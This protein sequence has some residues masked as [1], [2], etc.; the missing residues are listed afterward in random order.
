MIQQF[1]LA[2]MFSGIVAGF[3]AALGLLSGIPRQ[4]QTG[5]IPP[6]LRA[7]LP[8]AAALPFVVGTAVP[9]ALRQVLIWGGWSSITVNALG[10]AGGAI[11]AYVL[12]RGRMRRITGRVTR[13]GGF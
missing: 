4:W 5:S 11:V 13:R 2:A 3:G 7:Y 8:Q 10:F 1:I 9:L 6:Q 12:A